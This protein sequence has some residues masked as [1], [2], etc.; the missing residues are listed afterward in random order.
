MYM[1][2]TSARIDTRYKYRRAVIL[3]ED[4]E[5]AGDDV[6]VGAVDS[7]DARALRRLRQHDHVSAAVAQPQP[8]LRVVE[9][10]ATAAHQQK[11]GRQ[12]LAVN[13]LCALIVEPSEKTHR[14][15]TAP[16]PGGV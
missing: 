13:A 11:L 6:G 2:T 16:L 8:A 3:T 7:L 10:D 5:R 15:N 12:Q 9:L 4:V 1:Y 14:S